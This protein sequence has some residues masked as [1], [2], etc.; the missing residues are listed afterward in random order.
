MVEHSISKYRV[1]QG[2]EKFLSN[3]YTVNDNEFPPTPYVEITKNYSTQL[4][5]KEKLIRIELKNIMQEMRRD[6]YYHWSYRIL[7]SKKRSPCHPVKKIDLLSQLR[8]S[9]G[10]NITSFYFFLFKQYKTSIVYC[11][12]ILYSLYHTSKCCNYISHIKLM[13]QSTIQ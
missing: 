9:Y 10:H 2:N 3:S 11:K 12:C 1:V 8:Y 5:K 4:H 13:V 7:H 6:K